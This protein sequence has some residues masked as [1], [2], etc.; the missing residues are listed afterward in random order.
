MCVLAG[1]PDTYTGEAVNAANLSWCEGL[2][3]IGKTYKGHQHTVDDAR[4]GSA[5]V[6]TDTGAPNGQI[7]GERKAEI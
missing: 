2:L 3:G 4:S 7:H 1:E 5:A 6:M